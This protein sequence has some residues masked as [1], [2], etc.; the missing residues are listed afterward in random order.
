MLF[1]SPFGY[2]P[3]PIQLT[4]R[5]RQKRVN[6]FF[7]QSPTHFSHKQSLTGSCQFFHSGLSALACWCCLW[8]SISPPTGCSDLNLASLDIAQFKATLKTR[9]SSPIIHIVQPNK[10]H[11]QHKCHCQIPNYTEVNSTSALKYKY[12][13]AYSFE[14]SNYCNRRP[15]ESSDAH[16][17]GSSVRVFRNTQAARTYA[18][19]KTEFPL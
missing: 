3:S 7:F 11:T 5:P 4:Q 17:K 10:T 14:T 9:K 18:F 12:S 2:S 19:F 15:R 6:L 16:G 1:H 13:Y 8:S